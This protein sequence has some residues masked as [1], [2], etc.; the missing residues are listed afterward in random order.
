MFLIASTVAFEVSELIFQA[1]E[2]II[3]DSCE[4]IANISQ[5]PAIK[6]V[7]TYFHCVDKN[8]KF[9][10]RCGEELELWLRQF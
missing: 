2:L 10:S 5:Y 9:Q 3:R 4:I 1:C 7:N 6:T 8:A